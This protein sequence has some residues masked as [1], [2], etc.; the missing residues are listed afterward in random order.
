MPGHDIIVLGASAGGM[1]ALRAVVQ[2]LLPDLPA[3][4]LRPHC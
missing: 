4:T 1:E 3:A 2:G